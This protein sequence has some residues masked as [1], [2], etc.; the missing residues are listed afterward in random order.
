[1]NMKYFYLL[2]FS[3]LF[4]D[5]SAEKPPYIG[6]VYPAGGERG[7]SFEVTVGG[8]YLKEVKSALVSGDG[9][10]AVIVPEVADKKDPEKK[11]RV[12]PR[13]A[14]S[15]DVK[16]KITVD[17]NAIPGN[18]E[19]HLVTEAGLSNKLVFQI[20][21]IPEYIEK[22]PNEKHEQAVPVK[23]LPAVLN[24]QIMPGDEDRFKFSAKKGQSI[25]AEAS[26]RALIPYIADAVPGWFHVNLILY[27]S[28]GNELA[29]SDKFKFEQ[30]PVLFYDVKE[31]GEYILETRDSI[32]RGRDDFVYRVRIGELPYI[33]HI[34]PLGSSAKN[35]Q[36]NIYGKNLP[37]KILKLDLDKTNAP[38]I[39]EFFV[40]NKGRSSNSVSFALD[41]C[42]EIEK[43]GKPGEIMKISLPVIVNGRIEKSAVAESF[44]FNGKKGQ[45]V[46]VEVMA[47]R[48]GSMLDGKISLYNSKGE[49]L[50]DGDDLKDVGEGF[51]THHADPAFTHSLPADGVYTV[52]LADVQS[53]AGEN[54]AYRL[55]ISR[56]VP[57]FSLLMF[58]SSLTLPQ[59]GSAVF[60][61]QAL[62]KDGFRGEIKITAKDGKS[63]L[64]LG[65]ALI[66]EGASRARMT[67]SSP[68]G[69]SEGVSVLHLEGTAMINS[70]PVC[71]RVIS[72]EDRTQAFSYHH[73]LRAD[74]ETVLV[75]PPYAISVIPEFP[76]KGFAELL[77]GKE[78]SIP[79]K[80]HRS[81]GIDCPV[82]I[83]LD[84]PPKGIYLQ[85]ASIPAGADSAVLL[86]KADPK[87]QPSL[88]DNLIFIA[89]AQ[90]E[91][92][93]PELPSE[94]ITEATRIV[95][96][97][98]KPVIPDNKNPVKDVKS[99]EP[100][101]PA[102]RQER[103][104]FTLPALP[105]KILNPGKNKK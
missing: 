21:E 11:K 34:Y 68:A 88:K 52:K 96:N 40:K 23:K 83:R 74:A 72:A 36:I 1:M 61:V 87:V 53:G 78:I 42:P 104:T 55:R 82:Q 63:G 37:S 97:K 77:P 4:V 48:L 19:I 26:A 94:K 69:L 24:G 103:V 44:S 2:I 79:V 35:A 46:S 64:V 22:E 98:E 20:G 86:L 51:L 49:K 14:I 93:P 54:Y 25:V 6:Y 12:K 13:S 95:E 100:V 41:N 7:A 65:G 38:Y 39:R 60:T 56:P 75:S 59:G 33:T 67:I 76:D 91:T 99:A 32:Y 15:E 3:F 57:D 73:M 16:L 29:Y 101:K 9:V 27:D 8:Q 89:S 81:P 80:V 85:K 66:P 5:V 31:D 28:K 90:I 47:R 105:L 17:K 30:D 92:P 58:P 10:N 18:R 71:R 43:K 45:T 62:R 84:A 102:G 50:K 70:K